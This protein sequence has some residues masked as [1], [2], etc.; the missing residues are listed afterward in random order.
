MTVPAVVR[1][2]PGRPGEMK[3]QPKLVDVLSVRPRTRVQFPPPP[4][5]PRHRFAGETRPF[6][7]CLLAPAFL[8]LGARALR[9]HIG[10]PPSE[11]C[12]GATRRRN[13]PEGSRGG[14]DTGI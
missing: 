5:P 10:W 7:P 2:H 12:F 13:P 14:T 8:P 4:F 3:G 11:R 9:A 6:G 1:L